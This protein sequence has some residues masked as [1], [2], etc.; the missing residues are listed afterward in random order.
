M[1][2]YLLTFPTVHDGRDVVHIMDATDML[3]EAKSKGRLSIWYS[4]I[5]SA[6][7]RTIVEFSDDDILVSDLR[8]A[9]W[10]IELAP[11]GVYYQP[12]PKEEMFDPHAIRIVSDGGKVEPLRLATDGSA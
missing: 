2:S 11:A 3:I 6:F 7:Y 12:Q 5:T 1:A 4:D 8:K 9:G 10:A